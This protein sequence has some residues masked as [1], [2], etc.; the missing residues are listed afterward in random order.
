MGQCV[1]ADGTGKQHVDPQ[2]AASNAD[3]SPDADL[4]LL[5]AS[6]NGLNSISSHVS[7]DVSVTVAGPELSA[8]LQDKAHVAA[9][10]SVDAEDALDLM[11]EVRAT[12]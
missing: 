1:S 12:R 5:S 8:A 4:P 7:N 9:R 11:S 2:P 3:G 10:A 6:N